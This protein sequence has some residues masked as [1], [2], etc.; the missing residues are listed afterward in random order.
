MM[1][2]LTAVLSFVIILGST[3]GLVSLKQRNAEER[4]ASQAAYLLSSIYQ[5]N[6]GWEQVEQMLFHLPFA[7]SAKLRVWSKE[8]K[9][10]WPVINARNT[11]SHV[12]VEVD[13]ALTTK[14]RALV[15]QGD[16]IGSF[17]GDFDADEPIDM[18][19]IGMSIVGAAF[20]SLF[21]FAMLN[22]EQR[23][24]KSQARKLREMLAR[25]ALKSDGLIANETAQSDLIHC[26]ALVDEVAMRIE[27]L[28]TVRKSMVAD[29]AH[30]LRT[31][32]SVLRAKLEYTLQR[33]EVLA[34][35]EVILLQDE[36]Y[37]MSKLLGDLQQLALAESGHLRLTPKWFSMDELIRNM[38]TLLEEDAREQ[39]ISLQLIGHHSLKVYAD[40]DRMKQ[41]LLN[42]LG[43]ALR[44]AHTTVIIAVERDHQQY[45]ICISDDGSGMEEEELQ[46][47]FERFYQGSAKRRNNDNKPGLGLGLAIV[48]SLVEVHK[49]SITATS[50]WGKGT[51]FQLVLPI[52]YE[53][54]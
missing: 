11:D 1:A 45:R 17:S 29:I 46:H 38:V 20:I 50:S 33:E 22:K 54:A 24:V 7:Q 15:L 51:S 41:V 28:E 21:I 43:N 31:P 19:P 13:E 49:G 44:Y 53:P 23:Q 52:M 9:L 34:V 26:Q 48:K 14:R 36:V 47:V 30:E 16:I 25:L 35:Q 40:E 8:Q 39:G 12:A 27:R 3:A 5:L 37:R 10:I 32:L 6:D 4:M 2:L 42:I 18:L